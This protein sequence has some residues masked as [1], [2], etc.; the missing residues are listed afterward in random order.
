ME[1]CTFPEDST[2][3]RAPLSEAGSFESLLDNNGVV[4]WS[5]LSFVDELIDVHLELP[6]PFRV[7]NLVV[8]NIL[9]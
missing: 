6:H 7:L 4:A 8:L 2:V 5:F 9:R 1:L 3:F